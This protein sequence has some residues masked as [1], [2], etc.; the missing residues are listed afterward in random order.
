MYQLMTKKLV[1]SLSFVRFLQLIYKG[2]SYHSLPPV[3]LR[4]CAEREGVHFTFSADQTS[5]LATL[6][7]FFHLVLDPY[8]QKKKKE[9][10]LRAEFPCIV[11]MD[12]YPSHTSEEFRDYIR[13]YMPWIIM[14]YSPPRQNMASLP[15]CRYLPRLIREV[16]RE[17][18]ALYVCNQLK[19]QWEKDESELEGDKLVVDVRAG[20]IKP[21][22]PTWMLVAWKK[23]F[24]K[25]RELL[26]E[27]WASYQEGIGLLSAWDARM[28]LEAA[29]KKSEVFPPVFGP[30]KDVEVRAKDYVPTQEPEKAFEGD[31]SLPQM[32]IEDPRM[33]VAASGIELPPI[34][35]VF[36]KGSIM[37]EEE[38]ESV[39]AAVVNIR[40]REREEAGR[41]DQKRSRK[42]PRNI[43]NS[44]Y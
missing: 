8:F 26:A 22:S 28:Q 39:N 41:K 25:N 31:D 36:Q 4:A 20:T 38:L 6:Q 44:Q 35:T 7:E 40:S 37:T 18:G 1:I 34:E 33:F 2:R 19:E 9:L 13:S 42:N 5:H 23:V 15:A 24:E 17:L 21:L 3:E 16:T 43:G 10:N 14:V 27:S 32:V 11:V 29:D 30:W 12:C